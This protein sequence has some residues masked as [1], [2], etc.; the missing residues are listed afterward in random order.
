MIS[1]FYLFRDSNIATL[2]LV[3]PISFR[4]QA[5]SSSEAHYRSLIENYNLMRF[6]N[7][8]ASRSTWPWQLAVFV[9]SMHKSQPPVP[10]RNP[11]SSKSGHFC[12]NSY[13]E[14]SRPLR[15]SA[16]FC[17]FVLVN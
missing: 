5:L 13:L 12:V 7:E 10:E 2:P 4:G 15:L 9:D 3:P 17:H 1:L 14:R 6:R 16:R 8:V 11:D